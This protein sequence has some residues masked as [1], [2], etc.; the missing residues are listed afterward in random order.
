MSTERLI[1]EC[2]ACTA[3]RVVP[4]KGIAFVLGAY[5]THQLPAGV[6]VIL[7]D[8]HDAHWKEIKE[9]RKFERVVLVLPDSDNKDLS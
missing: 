9:S 5:I 2:P 7:C 1:G 4:D 3:E 6:G 8:K